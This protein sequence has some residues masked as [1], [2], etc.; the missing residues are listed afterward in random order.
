ME[1]EKAYSLN[2]GTFT[3]ALDWKLFKKTSISLANIQAKVLKLVASLKENSN[4][5]EIEELYCQ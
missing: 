5:K 4:Y 3:S 1:N 2:D